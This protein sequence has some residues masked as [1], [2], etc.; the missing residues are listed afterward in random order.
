MAEGADAATL[1]FEN[2]FTGGILT[3]TYEQGSAV[4]RSDSVSALAIV[5][6]LISREATARRVSVTD[7]FQVL[8]EILI[9]QG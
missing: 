1:Q 8:V 6:E 2:V 5:K 4:L 9:S 3:A 7:T